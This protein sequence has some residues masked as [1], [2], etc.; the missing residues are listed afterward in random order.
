[1]MMAAEV[2]AEPDRFCA[3]HGAGVCA[4]CPRFKG[5]MVDCGGNIRGKLRHLYVKCERTVKEME[6]YE[7]C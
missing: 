1:M 4:E 2:F 5:Y 6:G 7:E 3:E